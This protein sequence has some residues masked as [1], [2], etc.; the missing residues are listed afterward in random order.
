[1]MAKFVYIYNDSGSTDYLLGGSLVMKDGMIDRL[2]FNGGYA[3]ATAISPT[4]YGFS[5]YISTQQNSVY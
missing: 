3:K 4:T 2:L 5:M 1:M